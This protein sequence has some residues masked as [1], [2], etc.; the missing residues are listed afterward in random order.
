MDF[1]EYFSQVNGNGFLATSNSRGEVNVA[2][3]SRPQIMKDGSFV[4]GMTD[5]LTHTNL[6][7]NPRAVYAF[8]EGSYR[9][10]RFYLYK[11]KEET[12][13]QVLD[14]IRK[15]ADKYAFPGAG[16]AVKYVVYFR[17]DNELPLVVEKCAG[18]HA[19][20]LCEVAGKERFDLI[21]ELSKK[22]DYMCMNCGRMADGRNSLC[23]PM[24]IE[25][26]PSS[27]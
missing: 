1:T 16:K 15:A 3:Y 14:E 24:A 25:D 7:E 26:I 13:G 21:K 9:G 19:Q 27:H 2:V 18:D 11:V 17:L 10:R 22:P 8:H 5:R 12:S 23:N 20:H 6:Q 4:F